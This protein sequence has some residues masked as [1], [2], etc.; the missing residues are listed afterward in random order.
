MALLKEM[1]NGLRIALTTLFLSVTAILFAIAFT[2]TCAAD[3]AT[4]RVVLTSDALLVNLLGL[5]IAFGDAALLSKCKIDDDRADA[6]VALMLV[7]TFLCGLFFVVVCELSASGTAK[8]LLT[9]SR[10]AA[11]GDLSLLTTPGSAVAVQPARLGYAFA[12][13]IMVR[14][15][16]QEATLPFAVA[17]VILLLF[18][19]FFIA[20]FVRHVFQDA[21][22]TFLAALLLLFCQPLLL[23]AKV[24]SN[25]FLSLALSAVSMALFARYL[26]KKHWAALTFSVLFCALSALVRPESLLVVVALLAIL[27][28]T[29]LMQQRYLLLAAGAGLVAV[30]LLLP[31]GVQKGYEKRAG[32][33]MAAAVP[34]SAFLVSGRSVTEA[35]LGMADGFPEALS[36]RALTGDAQKEAIASQSEAYEQLRLENNVSRLDF[37]LQKLAE[38]WNEPTL[39]ALNGT[40][41]EDGS[42]FSKLAEEFHAGDTGKRLLHFSNQILGILYGL[43]IIGGAVMLWK[44]DPIAMLPGCI[45]AGAFICHLLYPAAT[46]DSAF[47]LPLFVPYAVAGPC[48]IADKI[49]LPARKQKKRHVV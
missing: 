23:Y 12:L 7:L 33:T 35:G 30:T 22:I 28:L 43:A 17:N 13:E 20:D 1:S 3:P 9:F 2:T 48:W 38:S 27:L 49:K 42:M 25:V 40:F 31:F 34:V 26:R 14:L 15:F 21:R 45:I 24:L 36:I 32:V 6:M 5:A 4:G 39:S 18:A 41:R 8:E 10:Q 29:A 47:Y 11:T 19:Y 44:K 37:L 16:G 46:D